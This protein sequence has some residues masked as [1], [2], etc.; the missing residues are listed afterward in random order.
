[1][2][3]LSKNMSDEEIKIKIKTDTGATEW[4][5]EE[6]PISP[7]NELLWALAIFGFAVVIFS[8]MLKN[9]LL[10]IIVALTAF[11]I[12]ISKNKNPEIHDFKLDNIGFY[13]DGKIYPYENFESFWILPDQ[14]IALRRK[15]HFM[16]LLIVPFRGHKE[17]EIRKVIENYLPENEEEE[18]LLD[19]LKK[20]FF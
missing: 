4:Q 1:M 10:V 16:P 9:Y 15:H 11:I 5:F 19:L 14:E 13:I 2:V 18:P 12:F 7:K 20:K 17:S 3:I 6:R 8:I